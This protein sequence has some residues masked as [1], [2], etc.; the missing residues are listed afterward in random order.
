MYMYMERRGER[1]H[2][3]SN[4]NVI[5]P[6]ARK[7][8]C[9]Y[10][11]E[12]RSLLKFANRSKRSA[13]KRTNKNVDY[14]NYNDNEKESCMKQIRGRLKRWGRRAKIIFWYASFQSLA[15]NKYCYVS[16]ERWDNVSHMDDTWSF[17]FHWRSIYESVFFT[18]ASNTLRRHTSRHVKM[19]LYQV[20]FWLTSSIFTHLHKWHTHSCNPYGYEIH[21]I[22]INRYKDI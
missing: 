6:N 19:S 11:N 12:W 13:E 7:W 18:P 22:Y 5:R 21:N 3:T 8:N 1:A 4:W 17:C 9:L 20:T 14:D 2:S 16:Q 15:H 10:S